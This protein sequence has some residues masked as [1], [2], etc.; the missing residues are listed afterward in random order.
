MDNS[1]K[2]R[3]HDTFS[4]IAPLSEND[5]ELAV[6]YFMTQTYQPKEYIFCGI[7]VSDVHLFDGIGRYFYI[8]EQ[9]HGA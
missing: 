2:I 4:A 5:V 8:D 7:F 9:G 3:L 1:H 6:Q